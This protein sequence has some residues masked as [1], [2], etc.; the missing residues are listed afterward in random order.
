MQFFFCCSVPSEQILNHSAFYHRIECPNWLDYKNDIFMKAC[1]YCI[2]KN[3]KC[4][5]SNE[6]I[7]KYKY[8]LALTLV[9]KKN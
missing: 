9:C 1:S 7:S 4:E 3:N 5:R 8:P 6:P 2:Q